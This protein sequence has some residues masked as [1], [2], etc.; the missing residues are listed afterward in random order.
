[1]KAFRSKVDTHYLT[2][3]VALVLLVDGG[4]TVIMTQ[5]MTPLVLPHLLNAF[6]FLALPTLLL[7]FFVPIRYFVSRHTLSVHSGLLRWRIP[8]E[9]IHRITPIQ[10]IRPGPALSLQ[11]LRI[12]YGSNSRSKKLDISPKDPQAFLKALNATDPELEYKNDGIVR[13]TAGKVILLANYGR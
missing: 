6:I 9:K 12:E 1:M 7:I 2:L 10:G 3:L 5:V 8:L 13:Y 11:R 4:G